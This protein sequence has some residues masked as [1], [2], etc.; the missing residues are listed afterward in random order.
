[1][2][3]FS[4]NKSEKAIELE[5]ANLFRSSN[6]INLIYQAGQNIDRIVSVFK[7]CQMSNKI[8]VLDIYL[9]FSKSI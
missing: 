9:A 1:M 2:N 5:L 6:K 8:L 4:Q 3:W 7:A